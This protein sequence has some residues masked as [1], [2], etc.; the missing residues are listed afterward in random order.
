MQ[1]ADPSKIE[2]EDFPGNSNRRKRPVPEK[3]EPQAK[4]VEKVVS[5]AV[6]QRKKPLGR[7]VKEVFFGGDAKGVFAFV[8]QDIIVPSG[9]DLFFDAGQ[10]ALERSVYGEAR[11]GRRRPGGLGGALVQNMAYHQ[12]SRNSSPRREDPR[13]RGPSP[14][15]RRIHDFREIV[16]SSRREAED[17]LLGLDHQIERYQMA[18]VADLYDL[19]DIERNYTDAKWGWF[20]LSNARVQHISGRDGGYLL[21]LPRP[22]PLE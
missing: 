1:P 18:S 10:A 13:D 4:K 5:G 15:A 20:D 3:V 12:M 21:D 16:L 6:V 14:R 11:G 9:R 7:K 22:E 8:W 17:V 19:C 2:P